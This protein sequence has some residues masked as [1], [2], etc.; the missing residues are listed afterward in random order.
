MGDKALLRRVIRE[1]ETDVLD[2]VQQKVNEAHEQIHTA[3]TP[4]EM[5]YQKGLTDGMAGL[6]AFLTELSELDTVQDAE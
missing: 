2:E 4:A 5:L 3:S 6:W 1:F